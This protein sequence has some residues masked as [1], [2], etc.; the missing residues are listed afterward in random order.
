MWHSRYSILNGW[1]SEGS[2]YCMLQHV[3][4]KGFFVSSVLLDGA[5]GIVLRSLLALCAFCAFVLLLPIIE[6]VVGRILVSA[7]FWS[8]WTT[9]GRILRAGF[10]LKLLLGQMAWKGVASSFSK[11][12]NA[13]REY[14]VD[15]ECDILEECVPVTVG[16]GL[17][18]AGE[19]EEYEDDDL[20]GGE[21]DEGA[22]REENDEFGEGTQDDEY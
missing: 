20:V 21:V 9:W 13:V 11:V 1:F 19:G 6:Y 17:E 15:V 5:N 7:P 22:D 3:G 10:P 2:E 12:E 4:V 14:I 16:A 8:Q 18:G